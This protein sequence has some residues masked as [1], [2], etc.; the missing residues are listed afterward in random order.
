M[1]IRV[2]VVEDEEVAARAHA[3]YVERVP[4]FAVA[5]VARSAGEAM[6]HLAGDP[7]VQLVLLDMHLRPGRGPG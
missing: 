2:L 1:T 6:R 4:G 5:G 7:D 3:A